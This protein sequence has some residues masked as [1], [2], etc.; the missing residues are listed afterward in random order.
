MSDLS[1]PVFELDLSVVED[2]WRVKYGNKWVTVSEVEPDE[3]YNGAAKRL[4]VAGR[5]EAHVLGDTHEQVFK[6]MES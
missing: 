6:L 3:F 5:L 4:L 1:K 2:M